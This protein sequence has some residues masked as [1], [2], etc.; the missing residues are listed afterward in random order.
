MTKFWTGPNCKHNLYAH[1]QL[2]FARMM[3]SVFDKKSVTK[4][5]AFCTFL[6][7]FQKPTS[8]GLNKGL[9]G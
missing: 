7:C 2:N 5:E 3:I 1:D 6:T 8:L 9:C 4:R